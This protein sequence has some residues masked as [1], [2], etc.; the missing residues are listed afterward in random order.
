[1]SDRRL[2]GREVNLMLALAMRG[3]ITRPISLERDYRLAVMPLWRRQLVELWFRR[4]PAEQSSQMHGP[5]YRLTDSGAQLALAIH[6]KRKLFDAAPR[7]FQG[8][9]DI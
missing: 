8:H 5:F 9:G 2:T 1:M 7:A 4:P 6:E 3:G